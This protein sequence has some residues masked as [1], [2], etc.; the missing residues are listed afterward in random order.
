MEVPMPTSSAPLPVSA[1]SP[2]PARHGDPRLATLGLALWAVVALAIAG[3]GV[4]TLERRFLVPVSIVSA[5]VALVV[6]YV[7]S[8]SLR[9]LADTVDLR[10][11]ILFHTIRAPI[12]LAFLFLMTRGLDPDFARI[13]GYGDILSGVLAFV[14]AAFVGMPLERRIVRAWN[15]IGLVDILAVVVTAQRMILFSDHP[16]TMALLTRFPFAMLP[17]FIVPL[18]IATHLLVFRRTSRAVAPRVLERV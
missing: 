1:S 10:V 7:R 13:A 3:S 14:A 2:A 8:P 12:G 11:P 6:L 15:L 16:E 9:T 18:V 17:L 5:V 4:I